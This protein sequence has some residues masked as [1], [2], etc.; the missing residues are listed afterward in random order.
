MRAWFFR[1]LARDSEFVDFAMFVIPINVAM[2]FGFMVV[3]FATE[4][5]AHAIAPIPRFI[6]M[7][8]VGGAL[9]FFVTMKFVDLRERLQS[10]RRKREFEAELAAER[11]RDREERER[12]R[13][14]KTPE[15]QR[16][17]EELEHNARVESRV[18]ELW[19]KLQF[20]RSPQDPAILL[21]LLTTI[22]EYEHIAAHNS[23]PA[24]RQAI[25][26]NVRRIYESLGLLRKRSKGDLH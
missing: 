4:P 26:N 14:P 16:R 6:A 2:F 8:V 25:T 24:S 5:W 20:G 17:E 7:F 15:Q 23:N 22:S 10:D 18:Y 12:F 11:Q 21:Q 13:V 1:V 9:S 19:G 3:L